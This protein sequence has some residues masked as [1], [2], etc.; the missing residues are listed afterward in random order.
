M[1]KI[2]ASYLVSSLDILENHT[3]SQ[4]QVLKGMILAAKT[5][6]E[7]TREQRTTI[8]EETVEKRLE[9]FFSDLD[10]VTI[11][12]DDDVGDIRTSETTNG[13]SAVVSG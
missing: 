10:G 12:E 1:D 7:P 3:V 4:I 9:A 2:L 8:S 6:S 11:K 5:Q 13:R